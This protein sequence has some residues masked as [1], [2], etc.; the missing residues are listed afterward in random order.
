M[1]QITNRYLKV[2]CALYSI[3]FCSFYQIKYEETE[4][5]LDSRFSSL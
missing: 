2:Y 3:L 4:K 5:I 1:K